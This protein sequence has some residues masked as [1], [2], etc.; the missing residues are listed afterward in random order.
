[1]T[2][3][4]T[5]NELKVAIRTFETRWQFLLHLCTAIYICKQLGPDV[6]FANAK[7]AVVT[8]ELDAELAKMQHVQFQ[9]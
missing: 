7:K 5:G 1:M 2:V 8:A 4:N 9:S 6:N 3:S